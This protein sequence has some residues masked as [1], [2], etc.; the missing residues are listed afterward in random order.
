[1]KM[2]KWLLLLL[3]LP[4]FS[5]CINDGMIDVEGYELDIVQ[6]ACFPEVS[7][8]YT[9]P[10]VP[11]MGEWKSLGSTDEA[12]ELCQLPDEILKSIST[13]GL[14]DALIH[15]PLFPGFYLLSS[16]SS[17]LKWHGHYERFNS[18]K[19][20]FQ[21]K[22]AGNALVAYYGLVSF[23]CVN[24]PFGTYGDYEKIIGLEC[25]FT[26]QDILDKMSLAKKQEA[27][28]ALLA[29]Y[30]QCPDN[31][32]AIFPMVFIMLAEEYE[33]IVKYSTDHPEEFQPILEGYFYS[34]KQV[35]IDLFVSYAKG[36]IN[37]KK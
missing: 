25:L 14:I 24:P 8:K 18:A 30:A 9:Y 12:Y 27:V 34:S 6:G 4:V 5:Q 37:D 7:D 17:A 35:Y 2:N 13:P 16:S 29:N 15:A 23:D 33:P 3:I 11:G 31:T 26:K 10:I 32:N 21:R 1:M 22:D 36:F 28:T 19:E 20:L